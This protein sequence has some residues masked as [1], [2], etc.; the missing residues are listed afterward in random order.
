M[1]L[2]LVLGQEVLYSLPDHI[3]NGSC[4]SS[5][6]TL[7]AKCQSDTDMSENNRAVSA[8]IFPTMFSFKVSVYFN[9]QNMLHIVVAFHIFFRFFVALYD[10][11]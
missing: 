9:V 8:V 4:P 1:F 3:G 6:C 11:Q 7:R 2:S 5:A 10:Y